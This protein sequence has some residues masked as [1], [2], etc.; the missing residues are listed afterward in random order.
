M[1]IIPTFSEARSNERVIIRS[2]AAITLML[3]ASIS[4]WAQGQ[5]T[6]VKDTYTATQGQSAN[7]NYGNSAAITLSSSNPKAFVEF[8]LSGNNTS[9]NGSSQGSLPAGI[10]S[11]QVLKS[12]FKFFI[13]SQSGTSG[14]FTLYKVTQSWSESTLT[15]NNSPL[16][17]VSSAIGPISITGA[18][19]FVA[20]DVTQYVVDWLNGQSNYGIAILW[21]SGSFSFDSK[22]STATSH[23]AAL[24]IMLKAQKGD[25]GPS[26]PAGPQ[27]PAGPAGPPGQTGPQGPAGPIGAT[28]PQGPS[29]PAGPIGQTG[30]SGAA[31]PVGQTGPQGPIGPV[32]PTGP[33]GVAGPQGLQGPQGPQGPAGPQG[34]PGL[35]PRAMLYVDGDGTI[36]QCYNGNTGAISSGCGFTVNAS[37]DGKYEI[38]FGFD[39]HVPGVHDAFVSLSIAGPNNAPVIAQFDDLQLSPFDVINVA[40]AKSTDGTLVR[41][42]FMIIV[43]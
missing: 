25:S 9:T 14:S 10:S 43:F 15:F 11:D 18:N 28:G 3:F 20:V 5:G 38:R 41:C 32:G 19:Q 40:T 27:G 23:H 31:G 29:G 24:D 37:V 1:K 7:T 30:P 36:L 12:T 17:D 4:T 22:E 26:G 34:P 13:S 33:Q 42:K 2:V 6:L 21:N 35:G 8:R 16:Y 39:I